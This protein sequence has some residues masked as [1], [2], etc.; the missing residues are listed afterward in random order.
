V[1]TPDCGAKVGGGPALTPKLLPSAIARC[2]GNVCADSADAPRQTRTSNAAKQR[3]F[4][5]LSCSGSIE[6]LEVDVTSLHYGR[7]NPHFAIDFL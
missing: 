6:L 7:R 3:L 2:C 4:M 5:T 1:K